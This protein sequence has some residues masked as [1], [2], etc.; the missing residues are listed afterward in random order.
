[1]LRLHVPRLKIGNSLRKIFIFCVCAVLL[2]VLSGCDDA[3]M[4]GASGQSGGPAG[5]AGGFSRGPTLVEITPATVRVI[6]EEVEAIGTTLANE[7]VILTAQVTD[8]ISKVRFED[9]DYA[10]EGD[11]LI[12]LTNQEE[13]A[14]LAESAANLQDAQT[15]FQRLENL[16]KDGSIPVSQVDE[17][18]SR[19]AAAAAR[20]QSVVARLDDRLVR[21]PFSGVLGFRQVSPGTLVSPGTAI[22][23]LDDI[24]TIKLDFSIPEVYLSLVEPGMQLTAESSAYPDRTFDATVS[25]IGSRI[26]PITR[27]ATIRARIDNPDLMLRPG[28]LLTVR[29]TTSEREALMVPEG[30]LMQRASQ[31]YV[32]TVNEGRAEMVQVVNG[33]RYDGWVEVTGGLDEGTPVISEGVIKVRNGSEVATAAAA[34]SAVSDVEQG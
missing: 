17:A 23:S 5:R 31:A 4:P 21:A 11:I 24:A 20:Y 18:R 28:M 19:E 30:A 13:T 33:A 7:S 16:L 32:Y 22:T 14:L 1:V 29:L 12:E 9:G 15:Q 27:A 10:S 8:T 26:D 34:D 3:N 25:S 6:V 2:T